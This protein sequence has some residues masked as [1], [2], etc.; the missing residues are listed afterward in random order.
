MRRA[1]STEE[2]GRGLFVI[3]QLARRW[4]SRYGRTG[5]TIWAEMSEPAL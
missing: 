2:N 4:G 3:A 5:K 1:R